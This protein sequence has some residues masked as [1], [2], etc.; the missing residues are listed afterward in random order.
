MQLVLSGIW[1][2]VTVSI[3]YND[4]PYTTSTSTKPKLLSKWFN[5]ALSDPQKSWYALKQNNKTTI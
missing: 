3:S 4:N 5:S 1:T 2:R